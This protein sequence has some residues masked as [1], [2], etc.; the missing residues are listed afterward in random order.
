MVVSP[1]GFHTNIEVKDH[2]L[3]EDIRRE[4]SRL[5]AEQFDNIWLSRKNKYRLNEKEWTEVGEK[6]REMLDYPIPGEVNAFLV[7]YIL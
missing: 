7:Q 4:I 6:V 2:S 3:F 1:M 5:S